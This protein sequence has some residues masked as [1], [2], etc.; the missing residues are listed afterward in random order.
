MADLNLKDYS[1]SY[2]RIKMES[3]YDKLVKNKFDFFIRRGSES[4]EIIFDD[5]HRIYKGRNKNFPSDKV[6]LFNLVKNDVKKYLEKGGLVIIP[7]KVSTTNYNYEYDHSEGVLTGTD[8]NHAFWKIALNKGYISMRTYNYGLD[9]KCKAIRLASLSVLGQERKFEQYKNG[10]LVG[11]VVVRQKNEVLQNV[12]KDIRYSCYL[13]MFE[14]SQLL[15]SENFDCW[16]TDCIYY[17]DSPEN[18]KIVH[19]YLDTKN[20]S[21]KQLIY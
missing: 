5:V 6:F 11:E 18:R 7:E 20:M 17:R 15:G 4:N 2:A 16:K 19:D 3:T 12:Y 8:I 10:E 21:Y 13:M 1:R 14:I 9:D